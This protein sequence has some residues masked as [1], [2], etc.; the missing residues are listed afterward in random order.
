MKRIW[1]YLLAATIGLLLIAVVG[2]ILN[3]SAKL[4]RDI[5]RIA[6]VREL[7]TGLELRFAQSAT[8][9]VAPAPIALG[10]PGTSCLTIEGFEAPCKLGSNQEVFVRYIV[11]PPKGGQTSTS[12]NDQKPAYCYQSQGESYQ[13]QFDLEREIESLGL[14]KGVNCASIDGLKSGNCKL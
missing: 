5:T 4:V 14:S 9:P 2:N 11:T 12:C 3:S 8:Y 13:I 7:Q 10:Q 6:N 1:P